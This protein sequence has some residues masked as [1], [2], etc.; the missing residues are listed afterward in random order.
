MMLVVE[1]DK[2]GTWVARVGPLFKVYCISLDF[3]LTTYEG[4][5]W[6]ESWEF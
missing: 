1:K 6:V 2:D 4:F 5:S 3:E